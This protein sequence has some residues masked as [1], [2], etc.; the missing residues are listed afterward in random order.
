MASW[1]SKKARKLYVDGTVQGDITGAGKIYYKLNYDLDGGEWKNGYKPE[2]YYQFGTAFDLP[3]EENLNKA[4][5][6]LSGLDGKRTKSDV[7]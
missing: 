6:T 1:K 3:T 7:V 4:G 5:Y 2:D